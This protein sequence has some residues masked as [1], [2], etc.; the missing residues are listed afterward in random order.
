MYVATVHGENTHISLDSAVIFIL[1]HQHVVSFLTYVLFLRWYGMEVKASTC[2][3][4]D[5][6]LDIL[7]LHM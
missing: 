2:L 4:M 3:F 7:M 5:F 6:V 1:K